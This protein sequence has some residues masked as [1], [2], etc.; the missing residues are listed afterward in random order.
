MSNTL[1]H[2][3]FLST[4]VPVSLLPSP[5]SASD[6]F[7]SHSLLPLFSSLIT[8]FFF[9]RLNWSWITSQTNPS[10]LIPW[11]S[12]LKLRQYIFFF[13]FTMENLCGIGTGIGTALLRYF[14][15]L[16]LHSIRQSQTELLHLSRL[17]TFLH[18]LCIFC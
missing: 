17:W 8:P 11:F 18:F 3:T 13:L 14:I 4:S 9:I 6:I 5:L 10:F 15:T 7:F 12:Y 2:C 16:L 1:N